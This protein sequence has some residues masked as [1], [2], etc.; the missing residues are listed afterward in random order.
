MT[1]AAERQSAED[2][3]VRVLRLDALAQGITTGIIAGML[4]FV[5]TNWLIVKGGRVVGPNLALLSQFFFGYRVTFVGS[6]IGFAWAFVYGCAA[7]Y[8]VSRLY[9]WAVARG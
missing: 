6:L 5:A 2:P 8:L 4:V 9:N 3:R 1:E 7:G